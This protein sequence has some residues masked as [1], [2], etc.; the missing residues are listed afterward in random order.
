M[1]GYAPRRLTPARSLRS[2]APTRHPPTLPPLRFRSLKYPNNPPQK[3]K[4]SRCRQKRIA[5]PRTSHGQG[6]TFASLTSMNSL[7]SPLTACA[8]SLNRRCR[9]R[10]NAGPLSHQRNARANPGRLPQERHTVM[11]HGGE[12][13]KASRRGEEGGEERQRDTP[14]QNGHG[15]GLD[16]TIQTHHTGGRG[17]GAKPQKEHPQAFQS[18]FPEPE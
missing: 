3:H 11:P 7:R 4:I 2:L 9:L 6:S 16:L 8:S 10:R 5:T 15:K 1:G 12:A 18:V 14:A 17:E 13:Q